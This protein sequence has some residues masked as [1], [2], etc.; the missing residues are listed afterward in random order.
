MN[1]H[2][3]KRA[4]VGVGLGM[5]ATLTLPWHVPASAAGSPDIEHGKTLHETYCLKCHGTKIYTRPD[6]RI[7]SIDA[8]RN[9]LERCKTSLGAS[10]PEQDIRDLLHYLNQEFYHFDT[11]T[12][13]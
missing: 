10:W 5:V 9:Q 3:V 11:E 7:Q 1:K 4:I 8:L 2:A 12:G 13:S 6:R